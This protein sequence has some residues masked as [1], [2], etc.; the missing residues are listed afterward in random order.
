MKFTTT[1]YVTCIFVCF[2]NELN[3]NAKHW[4]CDIISIVTRT[5]CAENAAE[6]KSSRRHRFELPNYYRTCVYFSVYEVAM[7]ICTVLR[8]RRWHIPLKNLFWHVFFAMK[9]KVTWTGEFGVQTILSLAHWF[10]PV[11]WRIERFWWLGGTK[12]RVAE[13]APNAP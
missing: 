4:N 2:K 1:I 3:S 9:V 8:I 10:Q 13:W 5:S 11:G 7:Q 12:I 6:T